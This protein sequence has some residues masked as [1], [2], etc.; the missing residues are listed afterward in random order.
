MNIQTTP[1]KKLFVLDTNVL[2]HDP[3]AIFRFQEHDV[4]IPMIVLEELDHGKKGLTDV[5]RNVRQVSRFLD[6]LIRDANQQT[7][8]DGL[9]LSRIEHGANGDTLNSFGRLYFETST[10]TALLPDSMPGKLADNSILSVVLALTKK[11]P[12]LKVILVSKD[13]NMRIKAAT[14]ELSA[15][16]YHNDQTLDDIDL[17]YSGATALDDDFWDNHGAKMDSWQEKDRTFYRL[18]DPLVN[19]WY[20]NQ[21]LY[22]DNDSNFEAIVRSCN[23]GV[24]I[25]ELARD[26]RSKHNNVW[27]VCAKNRE[28]NFAFNVLLDP[29]IDFV[30]LL[31]TAGTGKTLLALAAGLV[32]T[33]EKK[34]Y[35]EI[36][37]T[38]ETMPIGEDIGFLPGTEEEKMAPWMGALMDNL[39]LLGSRS[40]QN[41]WEQGATKNILMNRVKIR[42]LTFMRGRTF[43]NRFLIIDEAQNLTSKQMKT[44]ITRAG[45]GTKIICIGNLSQ[46]DTPYLTATTSGLTYV[47]DRFKHW[48]YGA[49]ITLRRGERSRLADY[50]SDML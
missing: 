9:P 33:L 11:F 6:E 28:Q 38:R 15:E 40:G 39:E 4:F 32:M 49:H 34:L 30:T 3:A 37:M 48:P 5:A 42:S 29:E 21:Y 44:L 27:G 36:V 12:Y 31:G 41:E 14:L 1:D 19:E 43:L 25:L 35:N 17:L 16:D 26:Y 23:T 7:L 46:I 13:I 10:L 2:M 47:V 24:A 8:N 22:M 18:E 50:A 20:P 45:P